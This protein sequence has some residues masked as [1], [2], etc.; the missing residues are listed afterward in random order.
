MLKSIK[1][2]I[3]KH[4]KKKT[5]TPLK[6]KKT[7]SLKRKINVPLKGM[8]LRTIK[9]KFIFLT[10]LLIGAL[11]F[12]GV[13]ALNSLNE[14]NKKAT[15][16]TK[17]WIPGITNSEEL[18]TIAANFR[19]LE[20]E[21]I[22]ADDSRSMDDKE[23]A[24][25]VKLNEIKKIMT[26]YE[27]KFYN[28]KDKSTY[29]TAKNQWNKYLELHEK[30]IKLSREQKQ[31][32]AMV[33]MSG[34]SKQAYEGLSVYLLKL[35]EFNK[36]MANTASKDSDITYQRTRSILITIILVIT[37]VATVLSIIL[38]S[39]ILRSLKRLKDELENLSE[40]GGDLTQKIEVNSKDEIAD[41]A[42][43]LNKFL[44]N[45]RE[46]V[47]NV[48]NN[49][50][51]SIQI[52]ENIGNSLT[53]LMDNIEEVSSTTQQ[54]AAGMEETAASSQEIAA[55][56]QTI[57]NAT[58]SIAEKSL[59]GR[60]AASEINDRAENVKVTV[61]KSQQ[62]AENIFSQTKEELEKA[63]EKSKVVVQI[64]VLS[65]A[66]M[67]ITEQTNLLA[68]NAA[69]E[70]ARAGEAGRGFSVVADEIRKLAE[71]SN[72]TVAEIQNI[73]GNVMESVTNLSTSSNKLLEFMSKDVVNGYGEMLNVAEQYSEDAKFV[74]N[75]LTEFNT[76][77]ENL[78][79]SVQSV[80]KIVDQVAAASNEGAEGTTNITEKILT[81]TEE[82][83]R[84][85]ERTKESKESADNLKREI[86]KFKF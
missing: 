17:S 47:R 31:D 85:V 3:G 25:G 22:L 81:V 70:A 18:N 32:E 11:I 86:A 66:I 20:Y 26:S 33:I 59:E 44:G 75:I 79:D 46:I 55:S 67:Q 77:T 42:N 76:T 54:L 40:R 48:D 64:K 57:G 60:K 29:E 52:N 23:A 65:E 15:V 78:L 80:L 19:S 50:N 13:Y 82:T 35:V 1:D 37:I 27:G 41:L 49:S 36:N 62:R 73:T 45:I 72:N 38:V 30:V 8:V 43:N 58:E 14:I 39:G 83:N 74:D 24:M 4:L 9:G 71:Q 7:K 51:A 16:I 84:I 10:V 63:I 61:T 53:K 56:T 68:L 2:K 34:E 21:H 28:E 69:I 12:M 5:S 6:D